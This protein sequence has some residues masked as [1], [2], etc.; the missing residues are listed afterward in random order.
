M[1]ENAARE[2]NAVANELVD[3]QKQ[4]DDTMQALAAKQAECDSMAEHPSDDITD[5]A[6]PHL[7]DDATA[8]EMVKLKGEVTAKNAL[9]K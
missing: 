2:R 5:N 8:K 3:L 9:N 7:F 4:L 6:V 1:C